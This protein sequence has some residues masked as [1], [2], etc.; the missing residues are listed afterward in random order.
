[1]AQQYEVR[2][3]SGSC[4]DRQ[5]STSTASL[6]A[7]RKRPLEDGGVVTGRVPHMVI[8]AVLVM[9]L[10]VRGGRRRWQGCHRTHRTK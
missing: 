2:W 7:G 4:T 10:L 5:L 9:L 1:M 3:P 6:R 8:G